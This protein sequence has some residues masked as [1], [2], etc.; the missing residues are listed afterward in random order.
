[1]NRLLYIDALRGISA[2]LVLILHYH[3]AY[4]SVIQDTSSFLNCLIF[5]IFDFG[6]IG[7][8][9]FFAIS[10]FVIPFSLKN[11]KSA[12][13]NFMITRFF[14][15]YPIYWLSLLLA[16]MIFTE[17]NFDLYRI[18]ANITMFQKFLGGKDILSVYW[19]LQIELVFYFLVIILF[20]FQRLSEPSFIKKIIYF[21]LGISI[22]GSIIRNIFFLKVPI[23]LFL[24]LTV[25]FLGYLCRIYFFVKDENLLKILKEITTVFFICLI[26]I[27]YFSYSIKMGYDEI[28]YRY[29]M[30]YLLAVIVFY[31]GINTFRIENK[32]L[33]FIGKISYSI[34][35]M[36]PIVLK[37]LLPKFIKYKYCLPF[38]ELGIGVILIVITYLVSVGTYYIIE[39][40][41]IDFG[42][43]VL[44][45]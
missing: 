34:Y 14:R 11:N 18:M 10:G 19:T 5:G 21:L 38:G 40:P 7:V 15:L 37:F 16:C 20:R 24:G 22:I 6:K 17:E 26:P 8:V 9:I 12:I 35:L 36:H 30:S 31:V 3:L 41:S 13:K 2:T 23:A 39:K 4:I 33:A 32:L 42:K 44:N 43:K 29:F 28:W 27:T 1:M 45:K 25:M